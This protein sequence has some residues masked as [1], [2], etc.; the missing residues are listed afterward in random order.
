MT[1]TSKNSRKIV[2]GAFIAITA[3][4]VGIRLGYGQT[5]AMAETV[6]TQDTGVVSISDASRVS[7]PL[8][9]K[10]ILSGKVVD[11]TD[12]KKTISSVA[13]TTDEMKTAMTKVITKHENGWS[14]TAQDAA[15]WLNDNMS[16][17]MA[18]EIARAT[19]DIK[20]TQDIP[21][22]KTTNVAD[23]WWLFL[24]DS[25][26]SDE[27]GTMTAPIL[28]LVGG[29]AVSITV[30]ADA[31][32]VT[33][34]VNGKES[35]VT[36]TGD[37]LH[38]MVKV[39]LPQNYDLF[40]AYPCAINDTMEDSLSYVDGTLTMKLAD[41]TAI[42]DDAYTL[43]TGKDEH[44]ITTTSTD[45]K[46]VIPKLDDSD[47]ITVEYDVTVS[48]NLTKGS[49]DSNDNGVTLTYPQ[50][51]FDGTTT[52]THKAIAKAYGLALDVTKIDAD[53]R[54]VLS[55]AQFTVQNKDT[56]KYVNANG[57][58]SDNKVT[59]DSAGLIEVSGIKP[60]AY[61]VT[62]TKAPDGYDV[63]KNPITVKVDAS[64]GDDG[65]L[66]YSVSAK[67]ADAEVS[68]VDA[69]TGVAQLAIADKKTPDP[70]VSQLGDM[71]IPATA[72][73]V[74]GSVIGIAVLVMRKHGQR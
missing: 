11:G 16:T 54:A 2:I 23:G 63:I 10:Q 22:D 49:E 72:V 26:K 60:G 6:T 8:V 31:P 4:T 73:I 15:E 34:T 39:T 48:E 51:T 40:D 19:S 41:G 56:G 13:W 47:S 14:G 5:P 25:E 50:T 18:N 57:T 42:A 12:G 65:V 24:T 45:L 38:Y 62:E 44:T 69:T 43:E 55:G 3:C 9:G 68:S 64:V 27:D 37:T 67:S 71:I 28:C 1:I 7:Q 58:E 36:H 21:E 52:T 30:K 66:T 61:E 53:T 70:I 33:K 59:L 46:K 29:S 17:T 20:A 32:T 74:T 35:T